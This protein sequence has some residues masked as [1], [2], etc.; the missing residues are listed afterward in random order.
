MSADVGIVNDR[1]SHR[2]ALYCKAT[3]R[4]FGP[5]FIGDDAAD[6]AECFLGWFAA[7]GPETPPAATPDPRLVDNA[8]LAELVAHWRETP[9]CEDCGHPRG[10]G[11][12]GTRCAHCLATAN[13]RARQVRLAN[14][15]RTPIDGV[16]AAGPVPARTPGV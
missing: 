5:V 1:A 16:P 10:E 13:R 7:C 11:I 2:A 15:L 9:A 3:G 8:T 12:P 14:L 6:L 4:A